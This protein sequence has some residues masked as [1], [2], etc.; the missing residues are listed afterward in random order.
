MRYE[1]WSA[2]SLSAESL[3]QQSHARVQD[4]AGQYPGDLVCQ[5]RIS[6]QNEVGSN[7]VGDAVAQRLLR[8]FARQV[9][10]LSK[11]G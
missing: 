8:D 4:G 11:D 5:A 6:C 10:S 7:A 3:M 2:M 9:S 1:A